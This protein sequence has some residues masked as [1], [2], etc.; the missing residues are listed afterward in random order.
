MS[1]KTQAGADSKEVV[2]GDGHLAG[3]VALVTGASSGIGLAIAARLHAEGVAIHAM[4]R[5]PAKTLRELCGQQGPAIVDHLLDLS[6]VAAVEHSALTLARELPRLDILVHAAGVI[7]RALLEESPSSLFEYLW[8]VNL[9]AP[10]QLTRALLPLLK[11]SQGQVVFVNS[12]AALRPQPGIGLYAATKA[13][14]RALGDALREEVN[15]AGVRVL[16]VIP[17]RTATPMQA[18]VLRWE[19]RPW[20]PEKLLQPDDIAA[21]VI[22]ALKLPRT[23]EVTEIHM[24]PMQKL[25]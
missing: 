1:L 18:E 21:M 22:A 7:R 11:K 8:R 16:T 3:Q 6:D 17:G 12:T 24:R 25:A 10:F 14:L 19:G 9:L 13:G 23:A 2:A 15:Q 5:T 20:E 4:G